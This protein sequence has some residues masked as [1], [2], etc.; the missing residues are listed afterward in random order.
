MASR[1]TSAQALNRQGI[2]AGWCPA[3]GLQMTPL[4]TPLVHW[5]ICEGCQVAYCPGS[6]LGDPHPDWRERITVLDTC[7][8]LTTEEYLGPGWELEVEPPADA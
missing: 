4:R 2:Y 3:C 7:R 5:N 6:V 1:I 8:E